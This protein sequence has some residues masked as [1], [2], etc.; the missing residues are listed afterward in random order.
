M[1]YL[2]YITVSIWRRL[3]SK[4]T[5]TI[6][7]DYIDGF[8][9]IA[10]LWGIIRAIFKFFNLLDSTRYMTLM[11]WEVISEMIPFVLVFN[12]SLLILSIIF[13]EL[14]KMGESYYDF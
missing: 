13:M 8:H 10:V 7:N 9:L 1:G 11:I 6:P 12:F 3:T 14:D 2:S 5:D 4:D